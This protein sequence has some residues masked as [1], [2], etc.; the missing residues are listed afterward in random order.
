MSRK[1]I[2]FVCV[3][4]VL[5]LV[6]CFPSSPGPEDGAREWIDAIVN[7]DGNRMLK[8]T[9]LTQ[10]ES[11]QQSSM[12]FSAFTVLGQ[13]FTNRSVQIEGDV[14]DL[15]FETIRQSKDQAEVRVYGELRVAVLG[16]AQAQQVDE[17]WLM[18]WENDTWRW[19]GSSGGSVPVLA[20]TNTPV[21][22]VSPVIPSTPTSLPS[23]AELPSLP[24]GRI[25]FL[26]YILNE[27]IGVGVMDVESRN[28]KSL[29]ELEV[30]ISET[31]AMSILDSLSW[32]PD[33]QRVAF[34][35]TPDNG[36]TFE[37]STFNT[38]GSGIKRISEGYSTNLA[39]SADGRHLV[40]S[41][42]RDG[43]WGIYILSID[44]DNITR[45]ADTPK[46][47][48][49]PYWSPDGRQIAF[50]SDSEIFVMNSDGSNLKRLTTNLDY[51]V[52]KLQWS[53]NS[54]WLAF[55]ST[56][57]NGG[58]YVM[59]ANGSTQN[60]FITDDCVSIRWSPDNQRIAFAVY[61]GHNTSV[62]VMNVDRS[63]QEVVVEHAFSPIWSPDG[64]WVAVALPEYNNNELFLLMGAN[65]S[66]QTRLTFTETTQEIPIVWLP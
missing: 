9:C 43:S 53:P 19:C 57:H 28:T 5:L 6:S 40:F 48:A 46:G 52:S 59:N 7:Q 20:P 32:S 10:R 47:N 8:Y 49:L 23:A 29:F 38:D 4:V 39:W 15:K 26:S 44:N 2:L 17:T 37:I 14:S 60:L 41:S 61:D 21:P 56:T 55:I 16:S 25:V 58:V 31:S 3:M 27:S 50:V 13:L 42:N 18:V 1:N 64:K 63:N 30:P 66:N 36:H 34:T 65:K 33:G 62:Y 51:L 35:T 24:K 11:V 54:Q 12:W 22:Q 45:L